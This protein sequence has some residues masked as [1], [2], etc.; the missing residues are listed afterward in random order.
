MNGTPSAIARRGS[1]AER[2]GALLKE[3]PRLGLAADL[4]PPDGCPKCGSG[5]TE[6]PCRATP[7]WAYRRCSA[8]GKLLPGIIKA[9]PGSAWAKNYRVKTGRFG[10]WALG[11]IVRTPAGRSL[12]TWL[13]AQPERTDANLAAAILAA[14]NGLIPSDTREGGRRP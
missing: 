12:I 1:P 13:A 4:V 3:N 5:L 9:T 7:G 8:C 10:G 14:E 2:V 6:V 11:E